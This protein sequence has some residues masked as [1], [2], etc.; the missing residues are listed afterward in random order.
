MIRK[1]N[2]IKDQNEGAIDDPIHE[3]IEKVFLSYVSHRVRTPLNSII[4]FSKLLSN[5]NNLDSS[6]KQE[7][8]EMIMESGYELLH[9]FENIM[10]SSEMDAGKF[11][12]NVRE[13]D[14][15]QVMTGIAGEYQDR[16]L[17]GKPVKVRFSRLKKNEDSRVFTDEFIL[18]RIVH[19]LIEIMLKRI[20]RGEINAFYSA[21]DCFIDIRIKGI[22]SYNS[23]SVN[24]ILDDS[25][26]D[27]YQDNQDYISIKVVKRMIHILNGEIYVENDF[28]NETTL[29]IVMPNKLSE[30]K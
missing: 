10:D 21:D 7:F 17:S 9:Y 5:S 22:S 13:V 16:R 19:N 15:T 18:K 4:G 8:I 12:P 2:Y 25:F 28:G 24:I 6:T 14:L 23:E 29:S 1:L 20:S 26:L 30:E 11:V 27:Y 3:R